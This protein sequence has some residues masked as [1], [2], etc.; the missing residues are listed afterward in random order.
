MWGHYLFLPVCVVCVCGVCVCGVC[1]V[2]VVCVVRVC[3]VLC[4]VYV[5]IRSEN[6]LFHAANT[7]RSHSGPH[8]N[9]YQSMPES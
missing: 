6:Q 2:C 1:G 4:V 9:S 8:T 3:V 5:H 7:D